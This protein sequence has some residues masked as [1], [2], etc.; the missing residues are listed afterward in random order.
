MSEQKDVLLSQFNPDEISTSS[1]EEHIAELQVVDNILK[2]LTNLGNEINI[3]RYREPTVLGIQDISADGNTLTQSTTDGQTRVFEDIKLG[4][5]LWSPNLSGQGLLV[6]AD[7]TNLVFEDVFQSGFNREVLDGKVKFS[8]M[9]NRPNKHYLD[10]NYY[11]SMTYMGT[12]EGAFTLPRQSHFPYNQFEI[13][14][15]LQHCRRASSG[16]LELG[17]GVYL[18]RATIV[19]RG[20][21]GWRCE[22]AG[23]DVGKW[24]SL[25]HQYTSGFSNPGAASSRTSR[26]TRPSAIVR[27]LDD[28]C[29]FSVFCDSGSTSTYG[30][31][32]PSIPVIPMESDRW[33]R[34]I[35]NR[36]EV[37]KIG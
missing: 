21:S 11:A 29:R 5:Q 20:G 36:L 2:A 13:N 18:L 4:G 37:W 31:G 1:V 15:M 3:G 22:I 12:A 14:T 8:P 25:S 33:F 19:I 24:E 23:L 10:P 32:Y 30:G 16:H 34:N 6:S 35:H 9:T 17:P 28:W 26:L 7:D 27:V